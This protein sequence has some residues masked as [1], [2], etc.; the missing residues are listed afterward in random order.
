MPAHPLKK[1]LPHPLKRMPAHPLKRVFRGGRRGAAHARGRA[2]HLSRLASAAVLAP[3]CALGLGACA[4][5]LQDQ[6]VAPSFLEPLVMQEKFPVY[7]LGGVFRRLSITR[8]AR[9]PSGAYEIQYGNCTLGGENACVT[10]LQIVTS[11][12]NSFLP[13]G[14]A[15][16]HPVLLR[17]VVGLS[18]EGG[19]T[20]VVA[21]GGVVVDLYA[22]TPALARA[23][24]QAMVTI[25]SLGASGA[26]LP[27]ALPDTGFAEQPLPSQQPPIA[28]AGGAS[29]LR[30]RSTQG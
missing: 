26:P 23:A 7:W 22:S 1:T 10:P 30:A 8:V 6:P 21:T 2:S 20:L 12:D 24:A 3:L 25:N 28:P 29:A 15:P 19:R 14:G 16:Q 4:N 11:P 9:D 27:R 5:T 18:M 17:G 13:G